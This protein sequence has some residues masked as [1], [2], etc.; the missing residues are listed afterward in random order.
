ML[1]KLFNKSEGFTLVEIIIVLAIVGLI[2]VIIFLAVASAQRGQRD[3]A[4]RDNVNRMFATVQQ[5]AGNNGG[6]YP[7]VAAPTTACNGATTPCA[8]TPAASNTSA[9]WNFTV[10]APVTSIVA[11]APTTTALGWGTQAVTGCAA[12]AGTTT[13]IGVVLD[14]TVTKYCKSY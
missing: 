2:F 8:W 3:T 5:V 12:V 9:G 4:R 1:K 6:T 14:D 11:G 10:N 13:Y 7:T